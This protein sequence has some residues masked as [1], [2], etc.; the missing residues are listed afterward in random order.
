MVFDPFKG[1]QGHC[2]QSKERLCSALIQ[3]AFFPKIFQKFPIGLLRVFKYLKCVYS[4]HD[5]K[6]LFHFIDV[7]KIKVQNLFFRLAPT[8]L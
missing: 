1:A 2:R 7:I 4:V 3:N 6:L 8:L 5:E